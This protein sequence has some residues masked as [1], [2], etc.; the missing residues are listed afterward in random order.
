MAS[1]PANRSLNAVL[2][3]GALIALAGIGFG[4][5][6]SGVHLSLPYRVVIALMS[7]GVLV[8]LVIRYWHGLDE[9]AQEAQK[10]AWFCGAPLG[11]G[12]GLLALSIPQLGLAHLIV[13]KAPP[14]LAI[15]YGGLTVAVGSLGGFTV[16]WGYWWAARR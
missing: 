8:P 3:I 13:A 14:S 16:A 7:L 9:A 10:W 12:V 5:N 4:L 2:M 11:M 6:A 1:K 15:A